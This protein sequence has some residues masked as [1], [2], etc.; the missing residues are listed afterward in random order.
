MFSLKEVMH[1]IK[2]SLIMKIKADYVNI[3]PFTP[4]SLCFCFN[5]VSEWENVVK[6]PALGLTF[7][8][9]RIRGI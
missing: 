4:K 8:A 7:S 3:R 9:S 5:R 1:P 2:V 6:S